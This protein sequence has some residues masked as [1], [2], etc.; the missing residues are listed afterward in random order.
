MLPIRVQVVSRYVPEQ[1][2][3]EN[4]QYVFAY[5]VS[6][7]NRG[8]MGVTLLRR[9]WLIHDG[10]GKDTEV[11]GPGVVGEQPYIGPH[12]QYRYTSGAM[13]ESPMGTMEGHYVMRT[14]AGQE[15]EVPIPRFSLIAEPM[16]H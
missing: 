1:S 2:D 13:L 7:T 16:V 4:D 5:S 6:I 11:E 12:E 10:S 9:R 8:D 3:P 14:E 15:V